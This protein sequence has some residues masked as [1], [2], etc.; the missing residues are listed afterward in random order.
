VDATRIQLRSW[1]DALRRGAR[2]V[3]WKAALGFPEIEAVIGRRPVL[4]H[5]TSETLLPS[6]ARFSVSQLRA[7]RVET[8]LVIELAEPVA[9][10]SPPG[11]QRAVAGLAVGLEI[12]DVARPPDDLEGIIAANVAHRACVVGPTRR[13]PPRAPGAAR[14]WINGAVRQSA[15]PPEDYGDTLSALVRVLAAVGL[16]LQ[17]GDRVLAGSLTHAEARAGDHVVAEIE[18]LGRVEARLVE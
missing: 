12:V 3:G 15:R 14:I 7:P 10:G 17:A 16:E 18:H 6:G 4:G 8:E 5:L 9:S 11:I 1:D 2:R 13:R